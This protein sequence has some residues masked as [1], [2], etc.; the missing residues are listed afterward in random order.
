MVL[1]T[2]SSALPCR[3]LAHTYTPR[4]LMEAPEQQLLMEQLHEHFQGKPAE[5]ITLLFIYCDKSLISL[6]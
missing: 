4:E 6:F 2:H 3:S 1:V 5:I